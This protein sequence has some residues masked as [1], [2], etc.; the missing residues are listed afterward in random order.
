MDHQKELKWAHRDILVDFIIQLHGRYHLQQESLFLA[1]NIMDRFMSRREVSMER[2]QLVGCVAF[3]IATKTEETIAPSV[4]HI[5]EFCEK[6]YTEEE[7]FKAERY[8][9]TAI[10][11]DMSYPNPLNFLRRA[12]KADDYDV[13]RR[14]LAKYFCEIGIVEH[15]LVACPPS[16]LA[17]AAM[18]LARITQDMYEWVSILSGTYFVWTY[19]ADALIY[20]L[21]TLSIT[22]GI[23]RGRSSPLRRS[24]SRS[25]SVLWST[26]TSTRSMAARSITRF[27]LLS[28][29]KAMLIGC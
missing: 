3:F 15:R 24:S 25:S 26:S 12:S 17:A 6:Q 19:R 9:L 27:V 2:Y 1:I 23:A 4:K 21:Q 5:V 8:M 18:W 10:E 16:L 13:V 20:R 7:I 29:P 14:T 28:P 22:L 11:W